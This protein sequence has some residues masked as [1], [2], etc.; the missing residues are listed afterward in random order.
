MKILTGNASE[1]GRSIGVT[2]IP[3]GGKTRLVAAAMRAWPEEFGESAIYVAADPKSQ[4][5]DSILPA[6]RKRLV[7]VL[8]KPEDPGKRLI[9]RD[10]SPWTEAVAVATFNYLEQY[11]DVRT[12]I[13]D[14]MT[15]TARDILQWAAN[16][17]IAPADSGDG[18][19]PTFGKPGDP[20]LVRSPARSDYGATHTLMMQLFRFLFDSP[21]NVIGVFHQRS[22]E[23]DGGGVAYGGPETVG[24]G[25]IEAVSGVFQHM[26][27]LDTRRKMRD[28]KPGP[29][30]RVVRCSPH[31]SAGIQFLAGV[32][33]PGLDP[34]PDVALESDPVN[35][36]VEYRNYLQEDTNE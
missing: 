17:G 23:P 8:P 4:S 9:G 36:W 10:Y 27:R 25:Q 24:K 2:G 16:K 7:V 19:R 28:G 3:K 30:E 20:T 14:T 11:P 34:M 29:T 1:G 22:A 12:I 5:L 13:W 35:F 15:Q 32:R 6:D 26:L 33:A 18:S 21:L 31:R